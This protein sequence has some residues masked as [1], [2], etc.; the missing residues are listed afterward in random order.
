MNLVSKPKKPPTYAQPISGSLLR[1]SGISSRQ[2]EMIRLMYSLFPIG[3]DEDV[4]SQLDRL[5]EISKEN[6]FTELVKLLMGAKPFIKSHEDLK[7]ISKDAVKD[8]ESATG[9]VLYP[10]EKESQRH[11]KHADSAVENE[12]E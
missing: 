7:R 9:L 4:H 10:K 1:S 3:K 8:F 2:A 6:N 5:I 11:P 12:E